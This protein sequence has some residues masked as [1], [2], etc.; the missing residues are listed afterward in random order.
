MVAIEKCASMLRYRQVCKYSRKFVWFVCGSCLDEKPFL[1][2]GVRA[3]PLVSAFLCKLTQF[4]YGIQKR[5]MKEGGYFIKILMVKCRLIDTKDTNAWVRE[6]FEKN[7]FSHDQEWSFFF[8]W[9]SEV[10]WKN[11]NSEEQLGVLEFWGGFK[12]CEFFENSVSSFES[13][14]RGQLLPS[15]CFRGFDLLQASA[16]CR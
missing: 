5:D 6:N 13:E 7:F 4:K 8:F 14:R 9:N 16:M 15:S 3:L 12:E 10:A 2:P 1:K 11:E